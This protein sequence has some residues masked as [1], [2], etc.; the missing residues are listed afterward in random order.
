MAI[1]RM[2]DCSSNQ[3]SVGGYFQHPF[4]GSK[5]NRND[6]QR[7]LHRAEEH[8]GKPAVDGQQDPKMEVPIPYIRPIF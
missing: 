1:D 7:L 2:V 5:F 3:G 6:T 8:H 4:E